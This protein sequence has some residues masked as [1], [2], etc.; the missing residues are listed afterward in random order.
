MKRKL[1][2]AT[3][4]IFAM[5]CLSFGLS[6]CVQNAHHYVKTVVEPGCNQGYTE[7]VCSSCGES[8]REDFVDPT[9]RWF[10]SAK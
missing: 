1:L 7:Y 3:L 9:I 6:A 10:L 5:V 2:T 4:A 8:Y